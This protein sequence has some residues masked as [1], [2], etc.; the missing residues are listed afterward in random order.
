[1]K[2]LFV[3]FLLV[4]IANLLTAQDTIY[5][6]NGDVLACKIQSENEEKVIFNFIV[7]GREIKSHSTKSRM[8]FIKYANGDVAV[9]NDNQNQASIIKYKEKKDTIVNQNNVA[10]DTTHT[11][12]IT[13]TEITGD[14]MAY[15]R[16][17]R[18]GYIGRGF[19][20]PIYMNNRPLV[21][22]NPYSFYELALTPGE[23]TFCAK[24]GDSSFVKLTLEPGKK[25]Y[26]RN[27]LQS[28][29]W[30]AKPVM[31]LTDDKDE[32]KYIN[33]ANL[34][35]QEEARFIPIYKTSRFGIIFGGGSGFEEITMFIDD[36]GD[37]VTLSTG[38]GFVIGAEYGLELT[39]SF[40][41]SAQ[42]FY[43]NST[44]SQTLKNGDATFSRFGMS[45]TPALVFP[46]KG[47]QYHKIR[48]GGGLGYYT[49]CTMEVD[50]SDAGGED[51]TLKY[52]SVIGY[53]GQLVYESLV[54]DKAS[55][56]V[57]IKLYNIKYEYTTEGSSHIIPD[58]EILDP[59][60]SG[61]DFVLGYNFKF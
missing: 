16:L 35:K 47:T 37:E 44:L 42:A 25:Y 2:N 33:E 54:S 14:T 58:P 9:F 26:I 57:G 22:L 12:V 8:A 56:S 48:L 50:A 36:Q 55:F 59:N 38:G 30:G 23:Y 41:I 39:P 46:I 52:S 20:I 51:M 29:M 11:E 13:E 40:D 5:F 1:M 60:G 18:V 21:N 34:A 4:I 10:S 24:M 7:N 15:V 27:Y 3:T 61:I 32:I 6:K 17:Y 43:Q 53:H 19:K 28:G 49:S 31:V 45:V